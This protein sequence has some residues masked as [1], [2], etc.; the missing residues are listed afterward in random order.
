MA[1]GYAPLRKA[2]LA[3]AGFSEREWRRR[4]GDPF[5]GTYAF[6]N[7]ELLEKYLPEDDDKI[8]IPLLNMTRRLFLLP[9]TGDSVS[10]FLAVNWA[11]VSED[12]GARQTEEQG[13]AGNAG[14]APRAFRVFLMPSDAATPV[15]P[16]VVRFDE[17]EYNEAWC[18]AHAQLCDTV[19]P[20]H[21]QFSKM[22]STHWVSATL[23]RIPL[24]ATQG[25]APIL[26]CMLAGLYGVDSPLLKKVLQVLHDKDSHDVAK[27]LGWTG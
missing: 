15:T 4:G 19:T 17:K 18:F 12:D 22:D 7:R 25:P 14:C 3:I 21:E 1:T 11:F 9:P 27:Q 16:T 24:A 26:V 23:P 10:G 8:E 5:P 2:L 13:N 20:Y 6:L